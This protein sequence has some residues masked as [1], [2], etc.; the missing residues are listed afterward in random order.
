M[1]KPVQ[2]YKTTPIDVTPATAFANFKQVLA[3]DDGLYN[4]R[5]TR[6]EKDSILPIFF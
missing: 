1:G 5:F 6:L 4:T 2:N 3:C